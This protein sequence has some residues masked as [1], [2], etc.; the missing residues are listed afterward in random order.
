MRVYYLQEYDKEAI[1]E[2][3]GKYYSYYSDDYYD[4]PYKLINI[5]LYYDTPGGAFAGILTDGE[6]LPGTST[7]NGYL[8]FNTNFDINSEGNYFGF[9]YNF[10]DV[11]TKS[12]G[13]ASHAEGINTYALNAGAHAEGYMSTASGKY[14]HA[15]GIN[16]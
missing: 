4:I 10:D 9:S 14:S 6:M 8:V 2:E 16:T 7:Y 11:S 12:I 15:E 5:E 1:Y 13:I 3:T